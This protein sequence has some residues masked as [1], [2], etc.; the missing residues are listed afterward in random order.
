MTFFKILIGFLAG[1]VL[2]G[3]AYSS[4]FDPLRFTS[5]AFIMNRE[6]YRLGCLETKEKD[7][8]CKK[9]A[10]NYYEAIRQGL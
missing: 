6:S 1:A 4:V 7:V 2:A 9:R 3:Y 8:V 5:Y 10:Q